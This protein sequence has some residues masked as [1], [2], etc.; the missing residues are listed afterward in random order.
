MSD[1]VLQAYVRFT[2]TEVRRKKSEKGFYAFV[3]ALVGFLSLEVSKGVFRVFTE[4]CCLELSDT[5]RKEANIDTNIP[6]RNRLF[7]SCKMI[8]Y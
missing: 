3:D 6:E 5:S 4:Q 2:R 8:F 7:F 1:E